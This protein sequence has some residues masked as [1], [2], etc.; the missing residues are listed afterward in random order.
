LK[1]LI[2]NSL[3]LSPFSSISLLGDISHTIHDLSNSLFSSCCLFGSQFL[4]LVLHF[5]VF[6]SKTNLIQ[7]CLFFIL[8]TLNSVKFVFMDNSLS[9]F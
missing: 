1:L 2:E 7:F 6:F 4:L 3:I 9:I 5:I 8:H